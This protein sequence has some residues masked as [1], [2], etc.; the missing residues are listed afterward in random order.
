[1]LMAA[2][3][4]QS[5]SSL[6]PL[7]SGSPPFPPRSHPTHLGHAQF[8]NDAVSVQYAHPWHLQP[9]RGRLILESAECTQPFLSA[10]FDAL[11]MHQLMR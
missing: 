6:S 1:M 10:L 4:C 5:I 2:A 3:D 9:T 11:P 7:N 8:A